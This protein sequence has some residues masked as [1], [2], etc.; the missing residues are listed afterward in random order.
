MRG[1]KVEVWLDVDIS[2]GFGCGT[3]PRTT[4]LTKRGGA[5][6]IQ[7]T[8]RERRAA[9]GRSRRRVFLFLLVI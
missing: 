7:R 3:A 6:E 1:S 5:R 2:F 4:L 8:A 9:S